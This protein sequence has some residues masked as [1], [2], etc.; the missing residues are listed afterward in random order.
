MRSITLNSAKRDAKHL[1]LASA[2]QFA[3]LIGV[4]LA[5][6]DGEIESKLAPKK[7]LKAIPRKATL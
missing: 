6:L 1:D 7:G 4:S 2:K 3:R 5:D